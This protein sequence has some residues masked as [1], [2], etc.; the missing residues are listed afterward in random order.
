[1]NPVYIQHVEG[2]ALT[3][4]EMVNFALGRD[5]AVMETKYVTR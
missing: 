1:M 3:M 4:K 5:L 2:T